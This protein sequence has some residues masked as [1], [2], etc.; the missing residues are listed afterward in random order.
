M[1]EKAHIRESSKIIEVKMPFRHEGKS[2]E[3]HR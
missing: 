1:P 3:G 2:W